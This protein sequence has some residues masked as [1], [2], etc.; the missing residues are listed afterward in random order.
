MPGPQPKTPAR[1]PVSGIVVPE[2]LK[3]R[4]RLAAALVYWLARLLMATWRK[5]FVVAPGGAPGGNGPVIFCVWHNRLATSMVANFECAEAH[6]KS[7]GLAAII[8]ASRDGGLL[9]EVL[10][11]FQVTAVRG[12][13]SRRGRQALLEA[14]SWIEKGYNIALTPDGP[15]GPQYIAQPGVLALAQVTATPII[16]VSTRVH[17]KLRL[18]SWDQ[19]Q[20]PLPFA[21]VEIRFGSPVAVPRTLTDPERSILQEKL[22]KEMSLLND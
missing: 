15:R 9:A 11:R 22:E 1:P 6:W 14:T 8:S 5:K 2:P 7:A 20:I 3:P 10:R 12:S 18:K 13:S 19:F 21:R 4:R 17:P 16:P